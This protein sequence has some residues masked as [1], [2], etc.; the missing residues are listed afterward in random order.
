MSSFCRW[1]AGPPEAF[2]PL[3]SPSHLSG[4]DSVHHRPHL[5]DVSPARRQAGLQHARPAISVLSAVSAQRPRRGRGPC[6]ADRLCCSMSQSQPQPAPSPQPHLH[7]HLLLA[8]VP[9]ASLKSPWQEWG[10]SWTSRGSPFLVP[11]SLSCQEIGG[12]CGLSQ[13]PLLCSW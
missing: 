2:P 11:P 9:L 7:L 8:P 4:R 10:Q 12:H 5:G 1:P 3:P 13:H 6:P